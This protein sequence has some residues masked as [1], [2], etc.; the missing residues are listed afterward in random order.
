MFAD[1]RSA[2]TVARE[3]I[4]AEALVGRRGQKGVRRV[5]VAFGVRLG[6]PAQEALQSSA[7]DAN[8]RASMN[9]AGGT[10]WATS[11]APL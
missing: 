4:G 9:A 5:H 6:H 7:N 1:L 11:G 2:S 10:Y 3:A 8:W